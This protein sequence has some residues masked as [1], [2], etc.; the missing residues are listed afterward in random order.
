MADGADRAQ[1]A[2][3][4]FDE[5]RFRRWPALSDRI[6]VHVVCLGCGEEIPVARQEA[7]HGCCLCVDC[8]DDAER[9]LR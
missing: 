6:H 7:M 4:A 8:Q 2:E 1:V 3:E 5:A 9:A